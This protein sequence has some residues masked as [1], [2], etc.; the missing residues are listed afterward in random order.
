MFCKV[1]LRALKMLWLNKNI[2]TEA[3]NE[4]PATCTPNVVADIISYDCA[5][6]SAGNNKRYLQLMTY[7]G[8]KRGQKEHCFAGERDAGALDHYKNRYCRVS[9]SIKGV[10]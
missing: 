8:I 9:Y 4:S 10:L 3:H 6:G 2:F 7:G 5:K 1:K